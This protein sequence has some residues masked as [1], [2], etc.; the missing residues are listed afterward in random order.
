MELIGRGLALRQHSSF[1]NAR[2]ICLLADS[3]KAAE[4]ARVVPGQVSG[5]FGFSFVTTV[6]TG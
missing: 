4:S 1:Y 3:H 5:R 2:G 6:A